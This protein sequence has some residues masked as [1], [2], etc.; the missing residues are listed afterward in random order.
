[1]LPQMLRSA[2]LF[3]DEYS[4]TVYAVLAA[5]WLLALGCYIGEKM[6]ARRRATISSSKYGQPGTGSV[7]VD[8]I[9]KDL[10]AE[11]QARL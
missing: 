8:R 1:M 9:D 5:I 7:N 10:V 11:A 6:I 4:V 2:F 3:A